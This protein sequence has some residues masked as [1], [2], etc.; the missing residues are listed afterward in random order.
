MSGHGAKTANFDQLRGVFDRS[1]Q[2][3][4]AGLANIDRSGHAPTMYP[5]YAPICTHV[6]VHVPTMRTGYTGRTAPHGM[7]AAAQPAPVE[8]AVG[9][10]LAI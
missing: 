5:V 7:A 3:Y 6:H 2:N 8:E 9:L 10:T 4:L 1:G